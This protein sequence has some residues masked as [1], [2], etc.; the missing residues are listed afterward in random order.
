MDY[1]SLPVFQLMKAKLNYNSERQAVLAQNVAN[2]DTPGYRARDVEAPDFKALLARTS[3]SKMGLAAT[4]PGHISGS[5]QTAT[6]FKTITR[7]ATYEQ[8]P[9]GNNVVAEEEM[10]RVAQTQAEYQQTLNLYRKTV[11][12][13]KA[14]LGNNNGA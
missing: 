6:H 8:S 3:K 11:G 1:K 10:M 9:V 4:R 5:A 12:L 2:V 14:A 13:F 7:P